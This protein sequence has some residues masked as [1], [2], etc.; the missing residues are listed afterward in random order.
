[1]FQIDIWLLVVL[2][3][4]T[5]DACVCMYVYNANK[6][7]DALKVNYFFRIIDLSRYVVFPLYVMYEWRW[8]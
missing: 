7:N 4:T 6:Q 8:Q 1:M 3:C 2:L 5:C